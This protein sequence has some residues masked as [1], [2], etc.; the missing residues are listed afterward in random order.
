MIRKYL[1]LVLLAWME[2][3][4]V[5]HAQ[6]FKSWNVA[7]GAWTDDG[8]WDPAGVPGGDEFAI[9]ANGGTARISGTAVTVGAAGVSGSA[10]SSLVIENGGTLTTTFAAAIGS[11]PGSTG[12]LTVTGAGSV[13]NGVSTLMG[14]PVAVGNGTGSDGV[15]DILAGGHVD[16]SGGLGLYVGMEGG[17]GAVTVSGPGS[18]LNVHDA[19]GGLYILQLG[20]GPTPGAAA[21]SVSNGATVT[22]GGYMEMGSED[23]DGAVH[24]DGTA[25]SRGTLQIYYVNNSGSGVFRFDG[26]V[27]RAS[28]SEEDL[29]RSFA[30]GEILVGSGGGFIDTNG[31]DVGLEQVFQ[32][33]G[34]LTKTG[35]GRLT[36]RSESWTN[37]GGVAVEQ[38]AFR[39]LG[40]EIHGGDGAAGGPALAGGN[41]RVAVTVTGSATLDHLNLDE[42][43]GVIKGGDGGAGGW[44]ADAGT[45]TNGGNGGAGVVYS[46]TADWRNEAAI[47]GGAGGDG[48][49]P[50]GDDG[51]ETDIPGNGGLGGAGVAL[52]SAA[53]LTNS[54]SI[55]GG[56]QGI[57]G[58]VELGDDFGIEGEFGAAGS[59]VVASGGGTVV[60]EA[61][62]VITGRINDRYIMDDWY[63]ERSPGVE[64][65]TMAATLV[66]AGT[67]VGG[68]KMG[69]FANHVTLLTGG[70][71]SPT[72]EVDEFS[73]YAGFLYHGLDMGTSAAA[74]LTLDGA[75]TQLYSDAVVNGGTIF[76]G[77]LV[78]AGAG[79]WT[80]D[81][82]LADVAKVT[83]NAGT[84]KPA[85]LTSFGANNKA[86]AVNGGTL[87]Y[88]TLE[89][90]VGETGT[91]SLS[92]ASGGVVT[93]AHA[94][95]GYDGGS[96]GTAV[97]SGTWTATDTD[98]IFAVGNAGH[99]ELTVGNGGVINAVQGRI[100]QSSGGTG[101]AEISGTWN[102]SRNFIV[103]DHGTGELT[104][105]D[106]GVVNGTESYLGF[107]TGSSGTATVEDG[108]LWSNTGAL[109]I[110]SS[111]TGSLVIAPGG[112]VVASTGT[113]VA[114]NASSSGTLT[115]NGNGTA[116]GVLEV[117]HLGGGGGAAAV[118]FDGGALRAINDNGA[119]LRDFE[120]GQVVLDAGGLFVD[121]NGH[122]VASPVALGGAGGLTKIGAGTLSLDTTNTY[123]GPTTVEAGTL[124]LGAAGSLANSS[125]IAVAAGA[126]FDVSA[127]AF[128]LGAAQ[129]LGGNGTVTGAMSSSGIISPGA[130]VG[131]LAFTGDLTLLAGSEIL[132][133]IASA[134]SFDTLAITGQ[135]TYGGTLRIAFLGGY[136]P[137]D[138]SAYDLLDF[139]GRG[140]T[141]TYG[142]IVFDTPG[143][144]GNFDYLNGTL[145]IAAIP[146]PPACALGTA[147]L[148]ALIAIARRQ[149]IAR[150]D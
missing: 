84:L 5:S 129:T 63:A 110:G 147:G 46:S 60:N 146:E 104:I 78:K 56:Y 72:E 98:G 86:F 87:D 100:G 52:Q 135:I 55:T 47:E 62:G 80:V 11:S 43:D 28:S 39:I 36:L 40:A 37:A 74:V 77:E 118:H 21:L 24:L 32:G 150:R 81:A 117:D 58:Y 145:T 33:D 126:T 27:L 96:S 90:R 23:T 105:K 101:E 134:A 83:V 122:A 54:G 136:L 67:I 89:F 53:T 115:V 26:G 95:V 34:T 112:R 65:T 139:G 8:N 70:V 45:G 64:A 75:G 138:G 113:Q 107:D 66:N 17:T 130:S 82:S 2:T 148:L 116:R 131:S 51:M 91:G 69:N 57:A 44:D 1:C 3:C 14:A 124:K 106:G 25:G 132:V 29:M 133:E 120:A 79:T 88:G 20:A 99:G 4:V 149:K 38:G 71:I 97:V 31:F 9:V 93:S 59:G 22:L 61:G 15:L 94:Y 18:S 121:S 50:P 76:H 35:D 141:S 10:G 108:G 137:A 142:G 119:F 19:T 13:W 114:T 111:G 48:G 92:I 7:D 102:N 73:Y 6:T 41:G 140:G 144:T 109:F 49:S 68:V 42:Q 128:T 123:A 16:L 12:Q 125:G 103:G 143:Y 30:P 127:T 85:S